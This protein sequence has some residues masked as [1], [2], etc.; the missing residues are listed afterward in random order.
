MENRKLKRRIQCRRVKEQEL[1]EGLQ[2]KVKD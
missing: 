1:G 2:R